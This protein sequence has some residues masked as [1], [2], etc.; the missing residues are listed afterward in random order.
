MGKSG[1]GV[2]CCIIHVGRKGDSLIPVGLV[3]SH[4]MPE[5]FSQH[6]ANPFNAYLLFRMKC[7]GLD[8]L[9]LKILAGVLKYFVHKVGSMIGL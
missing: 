5:V 7:T 3:L 9:N 2:I 6:T 4:I 8:F 1:R